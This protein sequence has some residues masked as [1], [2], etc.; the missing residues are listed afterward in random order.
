METEKWFAFAGEV[1][2]LLAICERT[3][4]L[5]DVSLRQFFG[6]DHM[7]GER[8]WWQGIELL[9]PASV[10]LGDPL[11]WPRPLRQPRQR[12][13][14]HPGRREGIWGIVVGRCCP[15]LPAG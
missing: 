2:A 12:P 4:Q 14:E 7:L 1:K 3:P 9:P 11:G 15:S 8:T 6:F 10:S 13:G 5:D